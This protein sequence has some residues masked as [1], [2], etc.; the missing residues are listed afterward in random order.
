MSYRRREIYSVGVMSFLG[1]FLASR[2]PA[3]APHGRTAKTSG[4][5]PGT[6]LKEVDADALG[7]H[8]PTGLYEIP[9]R[10]LW[11]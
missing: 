3:E 11:G 4:G 10:T 7:T 6:T 8:Q 5:L 9:V 2:S 1:C